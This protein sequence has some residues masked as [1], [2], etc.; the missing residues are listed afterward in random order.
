VAALTVMAPNEATNVVNQFIS[1]VKVHPGRVSM[2]MIIVDFIWAIEFP[3]SI[4][5]QNGGNI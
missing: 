4:A 2:L 3:Y 5:R 1:D